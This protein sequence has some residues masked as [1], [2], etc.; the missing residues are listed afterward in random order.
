M[1]NELNKFMKL[2]RMNSVCNKNYIA[3]IGLSVVFEVRN[4]LEII[5]IA[6]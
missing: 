1:I 2:N 4:Q 3:N 5:V 6:C